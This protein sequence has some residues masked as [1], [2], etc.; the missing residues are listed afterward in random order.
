MSIV[1]L[2][3]FNNSWYNPGRSFLVR[4]I[5][6]FANALFLQCPLNMSSSLKVIVLQLFGAKVGVG[7]V[8]KPNINVKYPWN[9]EIGDYSWIGENTWLDSLA[10]ISIGKNVCI[11]QGVYFCTGNHDWNDPAFGLI[12]KP[13]VIEDG[14]WVGAQATV[15]PGVTVASH[16]VVTAGSVIAKD[17]QPYMIY[18]GNPAAKVNER[19]IR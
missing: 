15:L 17:T 16:S 13:I 8:I 19:K 4:S 3:K 12:V 6:Y 9:L 7:V 14:A 2:S 10:P 1:D 18:A 11:S 5:W